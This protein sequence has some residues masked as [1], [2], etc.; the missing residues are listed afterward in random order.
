MSIVHIVG[1]AT[2]VKIR[3]TNKVHILMSDSTLAC[4]KNVFKPYW[5]K[6]EY[7]KINSNII[8]DRCREKI[9]NLNSEI[10]EVLLLI[11]KKDVL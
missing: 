11:G 4:G 9:E 1:F 6:V 7:K 8:C 2:P 10:K 5:K 3:F